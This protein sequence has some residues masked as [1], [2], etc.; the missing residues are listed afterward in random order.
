MG[1]SPTDPLEPQTDAAAELARLID[2]LRR[3]IRL[4]AYAVATEQTYV[5]WNCRFIR[6]CFHM[7]GQQIKISM[8]LHENY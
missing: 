4:K 8:N 7:L 1:V 6:F 5:Y 3:A 2:S